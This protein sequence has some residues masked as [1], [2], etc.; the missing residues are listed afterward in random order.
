MPLA[1]GPS[2]HASPALVCEDWT[3]DHFSHFS[4]C[5]CTM[6]LSGV[7]IEEVESSQKSKRIS[8]HT[9]V[10]GLGLNDKGEAIATAQGLVGQKD[11]R[12]VCTSSSP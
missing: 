8:A 1:H 6:A 12:E 7:N 11:A 9:H 10:K 5:A 4:A 3:R 2:L